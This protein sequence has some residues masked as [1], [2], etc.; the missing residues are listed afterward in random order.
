MPQRMLEEMSGDRLRV[1]HQVRGRALGHHAPAAAARAR[2][3]V[4]H[5]RR[6]AYG[7]LVVL[8][9]HQGVALGLQL[10]QRVEQHA[11]VARVQADGGLVQDVAHAAQVGAELRREADALRLAAGERGRGAGQRE[12]AE[13]DF[14]EEA[15]G[16]ISVPRPG[17][18]R[19]RLRARWFRARG[20]MCPAAP[21]AARP[22]RRSS[23]CGSAPRALRGL[24]RRPAQAGQVT[25]PSSCSSR[26][27]SRRW[28]S[29]SRLASRSLFVVRFLVAGDLHAGAEADSRTSRA[30]S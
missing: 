19:S 26:K 4:E 1:R 22:D 23:A 27:L 25:S 30:W 7:V 16:A 8:H 20:R 5:V 9:H 28:S 12:I 6:A 11:V 2:S 29:C 10:L 18:A 15:R 24:R 17:R 21:P 14:V 13:P 3:E